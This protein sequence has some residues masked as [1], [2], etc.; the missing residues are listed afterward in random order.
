L[1]SPRGILSLTFEALVTIAM[2]AFGEGGLWKTPIRNIFNR[3]T[4][5]KVTS[6]HLVVW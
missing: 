6:S 1:Y 3:A 2:H 4:D 5:G